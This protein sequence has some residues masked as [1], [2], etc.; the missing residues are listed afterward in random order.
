LKKDLLA[1]EKEKKSLESRL[2]DINEVM[3]RKNTD[4]KQYQGAIEAIE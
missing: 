2:K 1:S 4:L 3:S